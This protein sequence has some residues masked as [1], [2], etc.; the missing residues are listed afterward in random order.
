MRK[1]ARAARTITDYRDIIERVLVEWLDTPLIDLGRDPQRVMDHHAKLTAQRGPY[2]ANKAMRVLSA[3]YNHAQRYSQRL[4][5][6]NPVSIV[7]FNQEKRR[8]TGMGPQD[9]GTWHAQLM[10]LPNPVRREFHLFMLLSGSR[11]DALSKARWEHLDLTRR[12]LH[13][14]KPKGG[15]KR[16]F[17]IP[18][19]R[20]MIQCLWRARHAARRMYP[21]GADTWIFPA[22]SAMGHLAEHKEERSVLSKWGND[23]RQ[24]Y[25]TLAQAAGLTEFD[26][27]LLMNHS[28]PGVNAAYITRGSLMPHLRAQ[29][30]L[31]SSY[32]MQACRP[33]RA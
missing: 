27:Q 21:A 31:V 15:E 33:W 19:S 22:D 29:Q 9:L 24:T 1:R 10:R 3:V 14:P 18:L 25:R 17:N 30:Q 32:I 11:P 7:D 2:A 5:G 23:L 20:E 26:T 12:A 28:L 6:V 4:P 13:I 8:Q 16:A